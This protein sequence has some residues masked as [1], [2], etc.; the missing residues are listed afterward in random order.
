MAMSPDHEYAIR[1]LRDDSDF[2]AFESLQ[3]ETWG[4][5]VAEVV[6]GALARIVQKIGG[7]AAG[8]FNSRNEMVGLVFGFTGVRDGRPVHWSHMLAVK[9]SQRNAGVGVRLKLY[10]R[11]ALL[12]MGVNEIYWTYDPLV[13][14]NAQ[15][16]FNILGAGVLEYSVNMYG[17]GEDSKLFR[18][19]G[20]DRFVV[21]WRIG[22]EK[23]IDVLEKRRRFDDERFEHS[24]FV[25]SRLVENDRSSFPASTL[26]CT[27]LRVRVEI[28]PDVHQL[29][30]SS[31]ASASAWR[32]ATREA[33]Q[34]YLVNGYQVAG[35]YCDKTSGRCFYCLEQSNS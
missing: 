31:L 19:I 2:T 20:T 5:D 17:A 18:G 15:L 29:M 7:I 32:T 34:Q 6:T 10:Q 12:D 28:P 25:V 35:F 30:S 23:V 14:K 3:R 24:P 16:N 33:F 27:A 21:V 9:E 1:P 22:D 8:A 11:N 26:D 4:E 13:A